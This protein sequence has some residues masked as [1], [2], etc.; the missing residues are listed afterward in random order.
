ME[1]VAAK[2]K[3]NFK[4]KIKQTTTKKAKT[5]KLRNIHKI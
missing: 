5:N 2:Q 3:L 4:Q 1:V